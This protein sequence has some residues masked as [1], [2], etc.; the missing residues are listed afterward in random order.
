[1]ADL[2]NGRRRGRSDGRDSG[3]EIHQ[4]AE[5]LTVDAGSRT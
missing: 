2:L 5:A 4:K 3:G 1:M